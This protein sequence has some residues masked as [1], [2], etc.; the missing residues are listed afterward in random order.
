MRGKLLLIPV[1]LILAACQSSSEEG[2]TPPAGQA[3]Q[4]A[5]SPSPTP[6]PPPSP[7]PPPTPAPPSHS[8]TI[9][10]SGAGTV[11][12]TANGLSCAATCTRQIAAGATLNLLAR[13]SNGHTFES[14]SGAC[15]GAQSCI[16]TVS[17]ATDIA[18]RF[19]QT[20]APP[21]PSGDG[22]LFVAPVAQGSVEVTLHPGASVQTGNA[23]KVAFG[24]P[25]PR[26]FV[27]D[28]AQLR[29][30]DAAGAEIPSAVQEIARWRGLGPNQIPQSIRAA[31][32]YV[33]RSF[34]GS[35]PMT[36][37]IEWGAPR[38]LNLSGSQPAPSSLW[39]PISAGPSPNEYPSADGIREPAVYATL[40]AAWLGQTLLRTRTE[41]SHENAARSWWDT[42]ALGFATTAVNEVASS[43][44]TSAYINYTG[45]EEPWLFDRAMT[46]FGMYIRTGELHWLRHAH[47]AAQWYAT[48]VDANGIFALASYNHDLKY[49]YGLS[50]ATD[51]F[52]TGDAALLAPI[53]RVANAGVAEWQTTYSQSLGFWTERHHTYALRAALAAYELTGSATH[54]SRATALAN[55]TI[56]MSQNQ[57][58]CPLHT[59]EQ[60]E[61][62]AGDT[63]MMCSPWMGA[64]LA[65]AMLHYY[66]LSE[67]PEVLRWLAGMG[68]YVRNYA[69]YDGG[70]ESAEL[71]GRMMPWYMA[72]PGGV[73]DEGRGWG[74]MEHAC[75]VGAMTARA[76]WAKRRLG[77]SDA[78]VQ[79][80]A[81]QLLD[82]CRYVLDY[83]HR[84][85]TSLPEWRLS[86]SRKFNWWFGASTDLGWM[87]SN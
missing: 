33:E 29:V 1:L 19:A 51:Y 86:P 40:P 22:S 21:P 65:D 73:V 42:A 25:F 57:A 5:P 10:I 45:G 59:V 47:R 62:D 26:G 2:A 83:W 35:T 69:L 15:T 4:P 14:W 46:L 41:P 63:R 79:Q 53:N 24:V 87:L 28:A 11:E 23:V 68:D 54:A 20:S 77:Q 61:G 64:L 34:T 38:T 16:V 50:L 6:T 32:F 76:A 80:A 67:D 58:S 71:A 74:D 85:S 60:H 18:A 66:I 13:A 78:A 3:S 55:L 82:T 43:V 17:S 30:T 56:Q 7:T 37:K 84:S 9:T 72:G 12:D 44:P 36:I 31:L 8:V 27:T 75:D 52:F 49:S 81:T 39:V 48:R 70:V